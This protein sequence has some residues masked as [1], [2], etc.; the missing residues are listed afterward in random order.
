MMENISKSSFD[1]F[2]DERKS[3][4]PK[5]QSSESSI[6]TSSGGNGSSVNNS[7]PAS[8]KRNVADTKRRKNATV[9][10]D[11]STSGSIGSMENSNNEHNFTDHDDKK[12][13]TYAE[14]TAHNDHHHQER[15]C[16]SNTSPLLPPSTSASIQSTLQTPKK[17]VLKI[18]KNPMVQKI[19]SIPVTLCIFLIV[20]KVF[21]QPKSLE[22]FFTWMEHHP[23]KGMAAY[24]I[25][26]PFHMLLFLPGTPL[27]M[28]AGY[29][30]KI[31]FGWVWGVSL[32]SIITLFGSLIGSIMCF[33]LGRYCMRGM[34]RRWSKKY[35]M[36]DPIDSAVSDN[37]F[38][39]M[40][41]LYLTPVIPLGPL[42]YIMGTTSMPLMSFAKAKVAALPLT[43]L[44]VYLGA[45]TGT[46]VAASEES[47][48]GDLK[49]KKGGVTELKVD[50][51]LIFFGILCSIGSI[52]LI[53]IKM[54]KELQKILDQK[55]KDDE[56]F[57]LIHTD[58]KGKVSS[59]SS[60]SNVGQTRQRLKAP[61]ST[62]SVTDDIELQRTVA[63]D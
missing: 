55:R 39:I 51:K 14:S 18:I 27:V 59:G 46:L 12:D 41:M 16:C 52:A 42:S 23:N 57:D 10:D 17:I 62:K 2:D 20:K 38:K 45:A 49:S 13:V 1:Q 34:V 56:I 50:P 36:F 60:N 32:C 28:G 63:V 58:H 24:L 4:K 35:P 40:S 26:Y 22:Y 29:I 5:M 47:E 25:I 48:N 15:N 3:I 30:F 53:S 43:V 19:I 44:Y 21:L 7:N 11:C 54:K 61:R 8:R 33:L 37:S 6:T 9:K 31:R